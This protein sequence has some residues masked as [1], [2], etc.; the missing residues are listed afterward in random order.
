MP[1]TSRAVVQV[2]L[3][4]CLAL[5]LTGC[6]INNIPTLDEKVKSAWAQVENQYQRRADLVPNL[7]ETVKGFAAQEQET[8]TAVIEAR[9]RATSINIDA[10]S[11]DDPEK[12]QQFQ[13]AQ[14]QLTGAL[15]RLMAVSERYPELKS[16][17]NFLALQ[18]QL[19]GTEN[20]IAVARRDFIQ[21]V[22]AYNTE[23]RTFPGRLWHGLLYSDMPIRETFEATAENADQA[24]EVEFQ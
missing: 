19:E 20:R 6:G 17:Q 14:G 11:L 13:Q 16:N 24:P 22:E 9:S 15:S 21:A 1:L 18:S 4:L 2:T 7:V 3:W 10:D 23:I 8:L 12:L 5:M